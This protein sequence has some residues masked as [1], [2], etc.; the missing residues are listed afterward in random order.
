MNGEFN[1]VINATSGE[2]N[3]IYIGDENNNFLPLNFT[4]V[5]S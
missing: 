4:E 2:M 5:N 1:G 3:N